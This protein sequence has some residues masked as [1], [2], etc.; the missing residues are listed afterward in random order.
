MQYVLKQ[1]TISKS[2]VGKPGL[3]EFKASNITA[4]LAVSIFLFFTAVITVYLFSSLISK[5]VF[6]LILVIFYYTKSDCIW[7]AFAYILSKEPLAFF[8]ATALNANLRIPIYNVAPGISFTFFDLF[9]MV[10]F[11]KAINKKIVFRYDYKFKHAFLIFPWLFLVGLGHGM[12]FKSITNMIGALISISI[13]Y[14]LP[15]LLRSPEEI[16]KFIILISPIVILELVNQI[17]LIANHHFFVW[18]LDPTA[19]KTIKNSITGG[20]R[21]VIF[22]YNIVELA[23][24]NLFSIII[25]SKSRFLVIYSE[26]VLIIA[27]ISTLIS[28]TRQAIILLLF[29]ILFNYKTIKKKKVRLIG[30]VLFIII[31]LL[32][33]NASFSIFDWEYWIN[34]SL[35][36]S[37]ATFSIENNQIKLGE[38][39]AR[40]RIED[41]LPKLLRAVEIS[42]FLGFGFAKNYY[43]YY[44]G[45]LGGILIGIL[46]A[47]ILGYLF[48]L[49][50]I[51]N[52]FRVNL[53][54]IHRSKQEENKITLL[55]LTAGLGAY[56]IE[57]LFANP[58]FIFPMT[59]V[60]L[61]NLFLLV[62]FSQII[63][64]KIINEKNNAK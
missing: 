56:F 19:I 33:V 8:T 37:E 12:D 34:Q 18:Q 42:P 63:I 16:K 32:I 13:F 43:D 59:R 47:G 20:L 61:S 44:D 9:L 24:I 50:L 23:F 5:L 58:V 48:F 53:R 46:Q 28:G 10:A 21:P 38:G 39:S 26:I 3:I 55:A 6:I 30:G 14:S 57:N 36:R 11:V 49:Y 51:S 1:S 40:N 22:G 4:Y 41:R 35:K 7:I 64:K 29:I 25:L 2:S 60:F 27:F 52:I 54:Y 17:Y 45:H 62:I 15:R 31:V